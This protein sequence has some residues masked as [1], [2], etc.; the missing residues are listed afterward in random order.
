MLSGRFP[1][2]TLTGKNLTLTIKNLTFFSVLEFMV[3][4]LESRNEKK[5]E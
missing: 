4:I 2:K 5:K 3:E 1:Q